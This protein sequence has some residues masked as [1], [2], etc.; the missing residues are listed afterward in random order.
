VVARP[1]GTLFRKY[2]A[3]FAGLVSVALVASG[4]VGAYFDYHDTRALVEELQR[5]KARGA[6]LRIEE[7]ANAIESQLRAVLVAPQRALPPD[8]EEQQ[9]ELLRLLRQAPAIVDLAWIDTA[10]VQQVKVSRLARDELGPGPDLSAHE[11]VRAARAGRPY[12]SAVYFRQESEPYMT[13]ATG[14]GRAGSGVM[15]AEVNLKFVW[16]AVA[17]IKA[18]AAGYAYVVDSSGRLISHPDI[19][20]VLRRTDLSGLAPVREALARSEVRLS[21]IGI[22]GV[23]ADGR[24]RPTLTARAPVPLLGWHVLVEQPLTE[25]FAPLYASLART[26]VLLAIGI[27]LAV[28]ASLVLARRMSAPIRALE[29]G[30]VRVGEGRLEE[31]VEVATGDELE[32]LAGEFNRMAERLRESHSGL[33]QKIEERTRQ[34]AAANVAKSR[35]L[36]A[37]SHDL[38]QPVHALGLYVAQ[39]REAGSG[40]AADRL[41][42]KIETSSTAVSELIEALLDISELD[43]GAIT[44][45][46]AEFGVQAL[47]NLLEDAFSVA[48]Q[49]KGLRLRVRPSPLRLATD[50]MLLERILLNLAAN[51]VRY[52]REGGVLVGC[53]CRAGKARIEIWDTGIGIPRGQRERIFEEFYRAHANPGEDVKGLGLGLAIVD[54]LA[55]LLGLR[56][57]VR[58]VEGCGSMFAI[59]VPLAASAAVRATPLVEPQAQ[60]RFDGALALV[61]DDDADARDAAAGLLAQ[62]G[63]RVITAGGAGEALAAIAGQRMRLGAIISD[64]RLAGGELG[65]EVVER[66]R[67]ACGETVSAILVSGDVTL[68]MRAVARTAGVNLLH[69]PLQAAKLRTLL[70]R[71]LRDG[72]PDDG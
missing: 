9:L 8:P 19:S 5:E 14:S 49:A 44:P 66:V 25:A 45:H 37:A 47:L 53:R 33:E 62:W 2:A 23:S 6:A 20:L 1:R 59:E 71:L 17:A 63:W 48:A 13:V 42:A 7:F 67:R 28:G 70:H 60:M 22:G 27:A 65:T 15:L 39:L 18:G 36:A 3:Y 54:R 35:F 30:A 16:D 21:D 55:A 34:L 58:S 61:V 26:G 72:P 40:A 11:G 52:T 12:F 57:V 56:V 68:E 51:A 31:R 64:Y 43:A 32:A 41:L 69:K 46:P 50:P 38:R 24:E 29:A 4:L 10:G